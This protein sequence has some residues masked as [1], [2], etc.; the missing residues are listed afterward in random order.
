MFKIFEFSKTVTWYLSIYIIIPKFTNLNY[1]IKWYGYDDSENSWV[2]YNQLPECA[3]ALYT[4]NGT[5]NGTAHPKDLWEELE[6]FSQCLKK[7]VSPHFNDLL[8]LYT[9]SYIPIP[10]LRDE[11][12]KIEIKSNIQIKC[13]QFF[14]QTIG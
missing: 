7:G 12:K 5:V 11:E 10:E 4:F 14:S 1:L 9:L 13:N 3:Q 2:F 8:V 6:Q